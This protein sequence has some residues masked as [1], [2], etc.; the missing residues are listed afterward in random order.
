VR[1]AEVLVVGTTAAREEVAAY[2]RPEQNVI[3]LV[4]LKH[5]RRLNQTE[6]YEG[7]CW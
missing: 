3:D 4:D 7:I 6:Y 1:K 2:L 5:S